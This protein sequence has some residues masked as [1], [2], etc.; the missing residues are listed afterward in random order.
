MNW[1]ERYVASVI[2][3][4]PEKDRGEVQLELTGHILDML[5][6][7][8][9]EEEI[10]RLL[11]EMGDPAKLAQQYQTPRYLIGPA[12]YHEY[13]ATLKIVLPITFVFGGILVL[14]TSF[15]ADPPANHAAALTS[16]V[17]SKF[18][19]GGVGIGIQGL[20]WT[21]VGFVIAERSGS[22]KRGKKTWR[23]EDLQETELPK[24][25]QISRADSIAE[26]I[27]LLLLSVFLI[28]V[29]VTK[30]Q[31]LWIDGQPVALFDETFVNL[32]IPLI[33][34][35]CVA[36]GGVA[37]LKLVKGRWTWGLCL[38]NISASLVSLI[39]WVI[40]CLQDRIFSATTMSFL[41]GQT[42]GSHDLLRGIQEGGFD[43]PLTGILLAI[44]GVIFVSSVIM[45]L[46]RGRQAARRQQSPLGRLS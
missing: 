20:L 3:Q 33:L 25:R 19:A 4:L 1:I 45:T 22:F 21:T 14:V 42:W 9:T 15:L 46:Y 30:E 7:A 10:K 36:D 12:I 38:A 29:F 39:V 24:D 28:G 34:V 18:I 11:L 26:L 8:A 2:R 17:I 13:L 37:I 27:L 23:I 5:P 31:F 16:F 6:E 32:A 40:L 44:G 43:A 41:N 35:T